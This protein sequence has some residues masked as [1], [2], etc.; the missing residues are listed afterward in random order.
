MFKLKQKTKTASLSLALAAAM[1]GGVMMGT[2]TSVQAV[3][4]AQDGLGEVLIFPYYT[5]RDG[6]ATYFNVTNTSD[7]TVIA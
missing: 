7:K 2:S 1:T 4:I 5:V 6:W 3:N